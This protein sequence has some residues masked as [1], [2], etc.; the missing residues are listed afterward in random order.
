MT[1]QASKTVKQ[2]AAQGT[3]DGSTDGPPNQPV[4]ILSTTT[5]DAPRAGG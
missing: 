3:A 4:Q 5:T 2:V 1:P